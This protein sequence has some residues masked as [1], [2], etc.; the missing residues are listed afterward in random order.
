MRMNLATSAKFAF[1]GLALAAVA[2]CAGLGGPLSSP[3]SIVK[4]RANQRWQLLISAKFDDAY[5]MLAPGYR[6]VKTA[7]AYRNDQSPSVKWLSAEAVSVTCSSSDACEAKIKLEA[8]PVF[9]GGPDRPLIVTHFDEKWILVDG[10]WWHF[11]N[12]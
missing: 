10:Q 4:A 3:E 6:A 9:F 12:R 2:G 11:P 8:K 7:D 5:Q 1:A